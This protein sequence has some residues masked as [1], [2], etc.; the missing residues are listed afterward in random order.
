MQNQTFNGQVETWMAEAKQ[1]A[2]ELRKTYGNNFKYVATTGWTGDHL[3]TIG[4][5]KITKTGNFMEPDIAEM[6]SLNM[7]KGNRKGL[8]DPNSI[9]ISSSSAK[10]IFSNEDPMGKLIKIDNKYDVKVTG[11]YED[12][13]NNSS[14]GN[15]EFIAPFALSEKDLPSWVGWGNSWFQTFAQ[16]ADNADM[17]KVSARIKNAKMG[18]SVDD[19]RFKP[20][21]FLQPMSRWHLY[22][23]FKNGVNDG[24]NI[25][26]VK[27]FGIIGLFVLMLACI[28]FMNLSTARSE[29]RAK[30][31]GIRKSVGSL[32][33]QLITQFFSE[34]YL[35]VVFAFF[36]SLLLVQLIPPFFNE[37]SGKKM[38]IL[39]SSPLFWI[40]GFGFVL[41][42]GLIAGSYPAFYLSS[43]QPVKVLK[44]TFRVGR[45]AAIPRK[46]LVV[47]QFTVSIALIIGT[48]IIY[49][50]IQYAKNRPV[51]YDRNHLVTVPIKTEEIKKH[52]DAFRNTLLNTGA[53]EELATTDCPL[54][55]TYITNSG[56]RW[57]GKDPAMSEEFV[58]L[59]MSPEFGKMINWQI[60]EG[61]DFSKEFATDSSAF[62]LN[63]SAVKYMHLKN[64][65]GAMV[66][67]GLGKDGSDYRVIGV[68][69]DLVTQ[70]PYQP[71]KQT[72][73]VMNYTSA[74]FVTLKINPKISASVA[75]A[76]IQSVFQKYDPANSFE[77]KFADSEF[78][79]KF[80]NEER[81][82]RLATAFAILAIFISCLGL[83][84]MASFMAEQ[85]IKEIGVRKVL[86]A[87]V[88]NLWQ[89]LSK[90][91]VYL[92]IISLLIASPLVYYFIHDWLQQYN[93]RTGIS[94]WNFAATGVV[95]L[96][97]TLM[98]VSF[99]S[100][101]AALMNPVKSLRAE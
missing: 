97:I 65:I 35:V 82:G 47:V 84:G 15:L 78:A 93:Y 2:P 94:W 48:I 9:L 83:F 46:V 30:E 39:W 55:D 73:F 66:R 96:V 100:V 56:F 74:S 58:T 72:I 36:L 91:F 40:A 86:G 51:G 22:G 27:L 10:A 54:T 62:I 3:L 4:E 90:E 75:L 69:K 99:Q 11:V 60:I 98:T 7:L 68:V 79:R 6:L 81:I 8:T 87:S 63:E 37:V 20:V 52:Y 26:Y 42:T 53:V 14:F 23:D 76:K 31:V 19:R 95:T 1:L 85:R 64:P 67:W 80:G 44:G 25:E 45:F 12:M 43:F 89:L 71:V 41:F 57:E 50:Q 13:P 59:R 29:K 18:N 38:V 21:I 32:R 49:Q 5:K 77:Y 92:V 61:R 34:S 70:S 28:N 101:R 17:E 24:G 88:F 16:I 33:R